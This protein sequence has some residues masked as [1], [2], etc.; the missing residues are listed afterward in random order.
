MLPKP[1]D[2]YHAGWPAWV[3]VEIW[4]INAQDVRTPSEITAKRRYGLID[5]MTVLRLESRSR[6]KATWV[7]DKDGRERESLARRLTPLYIR[8]P[9]HVANTRRNRR[10]ACSLSPARQRGQP[11]RRSVRW[12]F[13]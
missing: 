5:G 9:N 6:S 10:S 11:G 12:K 8:V 7:A 13:A 3:E 2:I 4:H 1:Q